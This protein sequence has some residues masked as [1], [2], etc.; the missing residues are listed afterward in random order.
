MDTGLMLGV[1]LALVRF[2]AFALLCWGGWLCFTHNLES[3]EKPAHGLGPE[4]V[5]LIVLLALLWATF[6]GLAR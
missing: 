1:L 2:A 6:E 5:G 3:A 4:R